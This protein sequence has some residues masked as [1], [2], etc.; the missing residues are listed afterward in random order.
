MS[1]SPAIIIVEKDDTGRENVTH[2]L[3]SGQLEVQRVSR[4][5]SYLS[6]GFRTL[7][8]NIFLPAG[9]P[10]TVSAGMYRI[11]SV[12]AIFIY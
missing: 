8:R 9:Y 3:R 10:S 12:I 2:T 5:N 11:N 6:I 1:S 7:L 4:R